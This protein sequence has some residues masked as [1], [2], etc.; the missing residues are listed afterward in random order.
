MQ[1][2][3]IQSL[4]NARVHLG[5]AKYLLEV[6]MK[7]MDDKRIL[8]K[9]LIEM[10][11]AVT[12]VINATI[13]L[14][15][16]NGRKLPVGK[17]ERAKLFFNKLAKKSLENKEIEEL[18]RILLFVK[19]HKLAKLE[20]VRREKLVIFEGKRCQIITEERVTDSLKTLNKIVLRFEQKRKV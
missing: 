12:N 15:S 4:H 13:Y 14:N 2:K 10:Q 8:P 20:F 17:E 9:C 7:I 19:K 18:K 16:K 11:K 3:S 1:V 6:T 5:I